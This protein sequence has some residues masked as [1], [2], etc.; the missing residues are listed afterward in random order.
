MIVYS[1]CE[2]SSA[3]PFSG[4]TGVVLDPA[5]DSTEDGLFAGCSL[6][7]GDDGNFD[8]TDGAGGAGGHV[9]GRSGEREWDE[10]EEDCEQHCG[11]LEGT[12]GN[13]DEWRWQ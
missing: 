12:M 10:S 1:L 8:G 3:E 2:R 6:D 11:V 4:G 7:T 13:V 9:W 5:S